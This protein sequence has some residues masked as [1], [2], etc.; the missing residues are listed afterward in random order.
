MSFDSSKSSKRAGLQG[1]GHQ[2]PWH[3]YCRTYQRVLEVFLA[4]CLDR[5][6]RIRTMPPLRDPPPL[7]SMGRVVFTY[8]DVHRL[9]FMWTW[10]PRQA[11]GG[12]LSRGLGLARMVAWL[13]DM[14]AADEWFRGAH[15][16]PLLAALE[17]REESIRRQAMSTPSPLVVSTPP[18]HR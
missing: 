1:S 12:V 3:R 18:N 2:L 14:L 17:D 13:Q 10:S 4:R 11:R 5:S 9:F 16:R 6:K 7:Q 8:F 15:A